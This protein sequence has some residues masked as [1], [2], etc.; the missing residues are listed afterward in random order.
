MIDALPPLVMAFALLGLALGLLVAEFFVVSLGALALGALAAAAGAIYFAFAASDL[1]GWLFVAGVPLLAAG[2]VRWGIQRVQRSRVV[3]QTEI[4][5]EAGYHHVTDR[6]GVS[7][8]SC[9]TMV[10]PARPSGRARFD[11]G[12]CDVMVSAGALERDA[13]VVVT[14][15]DGPVVYVSPPSDGEAAA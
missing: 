15:I 14:R 9:G 11:G 7:I 4:A 3:P 10:T 12:E 13:P 6:I 2:T 5:G 8:G 1:A